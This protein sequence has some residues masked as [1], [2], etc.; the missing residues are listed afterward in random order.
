[1]RNFPLKAEDKTRVWVGLGWGWFELSCF[2]FGLDDFW[3]GLD[4]PWMSFRGWKFCFRNKFLKSKIVFVFCSEPMSDQLVWEE[5]PNSILSSGDSYS[6]C[7]DSV[8]KL[9]N[10][11]YGM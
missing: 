9:P 8:N 3:V 4:W 1:M 10:N 6:N 7:T 5:V 11:S 2:F